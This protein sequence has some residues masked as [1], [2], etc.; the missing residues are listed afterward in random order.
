MATISGTD[1]KREIIDMRPKGDELEALLSGFVRSCMTIEITKDKGLLLAL[2]CGSDYVREYI[3]GCMLKQ[4]KIASNGKDGALVFADCKK[5][6]S[7]LHITGG[8]SSFEIFGIPECYAKHASAYVRGMFLGCGSFSVHDA[9]AAGKENVGGRYHFEFSLLSESLADELVDLLGR[10]GIAVRKMIRSEKYVVYAKDSD[11]VS[12]CLALMRADK[13]VLKLA[14]T[15][16]TMSMKREI[17]RR[18]NC[19][20]ANMTRT[21]TAAVDVTEAIEYIDATVGLNTLHPKLLEA[22][23]ARLNSPDASLASLAYELGIS[24]SGLK[25]RY[26]KIIAYAD[27][28]RN[29]RG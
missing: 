27:E 21:A 28:L 14:D 19:D 4:F 2:D 10:Y 26:D 8:D 16:V 20:I 15:V 3:A 22:A 25:H 5:L 11:T 12:N 1:V 6:L 17:N 23:D 24:K 29:K 7:M 18:N 13:T 9:D